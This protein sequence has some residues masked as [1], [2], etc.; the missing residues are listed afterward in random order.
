M[1]KSVTILFIIALVLCHSIPIVSQNTMRIHYK[2][3]TEQDIAISQIDS[4]TF[5]EKDSHDEE[6]NVTLTGS[7]LWAK[8]EAGY[9]ELLNFND[10]DVVVAGSST[11][12]EV[13]SKE[14]WDKKTAAVLDILYEDLET[15]LAESGVRI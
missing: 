10:K 6:E 9:Y 1:R 4:I 15:A 2:D 8:K 3:G 7:W 12:L 14:E 5:V 13:W 11:R